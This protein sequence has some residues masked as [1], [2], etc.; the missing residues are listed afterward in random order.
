M[1]EHAGDKTE[2]ATP[3]RLEE[4]LR[5]G[6]FPRSAEVQ[7]VFVIS[8]AL[9]ALRMSGPD[10]WDR[11]TLAFKGIFFNLHKTSVAEENLQGYLI[12][13]VMLIAV[14]AGPI[15]IATLTS[16]LLAG[17]MQSRFNTATDALNPDW[18][19]VNPA[20]GFARIFSTKAF[21]PTGLSVMK[22]GIIGGVCWSAVRNIL[23]DPIFY[24]VLGPADFA[25]FLS[26]TSFQ[27]GTRVVLVLGAIAGADY[28]YQFWRTTRDLMMTKEELKEEVKNTEGDPHTKARQRRRRNTRTQ[29][30]MLQ[31]VPQADVVLTNP[32]HL[33]SALRYDRK[34]MKAPKIIAKGSRLN[35]L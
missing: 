4:A 12:S 31:E 19:R 1:S 16:A 7:T 24:T 28:G 29:R 15:V 25:R 34:T 32:T 3:K 17:G 30:K 23:Q 10:A 8:A 33:A 11:L 21:V 9:M 5:K 22:I 20:A 18:Q 26:Q 14:C 27:L 35:A 2:Q 13:G 6:Q